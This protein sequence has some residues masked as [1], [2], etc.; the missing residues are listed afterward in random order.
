[1]KRDVDAL[2]IEFAA[3]RA[4]VAALRA[5]PPAPK[6]ISRRHLV[7][8]L[9]GLGAAGAAGIAP[10]A[11]AAAADGDNVVLG[12]LNTA[13]SS[14]AIATEVPGEA[15]QVQ[16]GHGGWGIFATAV[17][18]AIV[19]AT[20]SGGLAGVNGE[21]VDGTGVLGHAS[22]VG[23]IG[24]VALSVTGPA[25]AAQSDSD[26]VTLRLVPAARS[27]PPTVTPVGLGEYSAGSFSVDENGEVWLCTLGGAPGTWTRI[28]REDTAS[29]RT[30]P[31]APL[32]VIDTRHPLGRPPGSPV[33][34]GQKAGPLKGGTS[35]TLDLAGSGPIPA[36]ATGVIGN[37]TVVNPSYSG[38]L[39]ARP[40]GA[41][42]ATSS[43]NFTN[44]VTAIANAF[45]SQLGP[46]GLTITGSGTSANTYHLV[47][48]ITAYIT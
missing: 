10:A 6:R 47:V 16:F 22:G 26:G 29:G 39:A 36:T 11:P 25:L 23:G 40:S 30:V 24:V 38:W 1:M 2:R 5:Q 44:G 35:L 7:T 34:P 45:T 19:G 37:L 41:P 42:G 28:L 33:V 46:A 32:R 31:I 17:S 3:L 4:E 27:G 8:G 12:Q 9:V 48:D 18:T 43:I 14:T 20:D 15:S 21:A 13:T